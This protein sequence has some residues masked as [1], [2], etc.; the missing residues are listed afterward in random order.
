MLRLRT[1]P[2]LLLS[3]LVVP[4][5]G[6][7]AVSSC[8]AWNAS[9]C[10]AAFA[11]A[12]NAEI[13][14]SIRA[15]KAARERAFVAARNAEIEASLAAVEAARERDFAEARNAEII[16]SI[17]NV[18]IAR[19]IDA[20]LSRT[21]CESPGAGLEPCEGE[22]A[23]EF[24][25]ARNAEIEVSLAAANEQRQRAFTVAR[26]AEVDVSI[27]TVNAARERS[28]ALRP[29]SCESPNSGLPPCEGEVAARFERARNAEIAASLVAVSEQ[30]AFTEARNAEIEASIGAVEAVRGRAFARARNAEIKRSVAAAE[31]A[32]RRAFAQ[33]RNAEIELATAAV[34]AARE[35]DLA[36]SR[37]YCKSPETATPRCKVERAREFAAARN[38]EIAASLAAVEARREPAFA[39]ARNAEIRASIAAV[40]ITR[41]RTAALG[42]TR[43]T[44]RELPTSH[45]AAERTIQLALSRTHCKT[46]GSSSPRC[47]AE[48][49]HE[50]AIARNMEIGASIATVKAARERGFAAARNAEINAAFAAYGT[51]RTRSAQTETPAGPTAPSPLETGAI[52]IPDALPL[53][54]LPERHSL[55]AEPCSA[56]GQRLPPVQF[57]GV[58]TAIDDA[59]KPGLDRLADIARGCP[60]VRIEIHGYS[61][62]SG[63]AFVVRRL[64]ELRAQAALAYL[65]SAGIQRNRLAAIGHGDMLPLAP[66]TTPESRAKNRRVE[67]TIKDPALEAAAARI[68][69]D[70]AD[71]LDPTY[72][73]QLAR[74]S[75]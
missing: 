48:R 61:D 38:A 9:R 5:S 58:G 39:A 56:A 33:A 55:A 34:R 62:A 12:R 71:L 7:T 27:A 59:M 68:M 52:R 26:N 47:E 14:A 37:T 75:P 40:T 20:L 2:L 42:I 1:F 70:L 30:R 8:P 57:S 41:A 72:V 50:F 4:A 28:A 36:L 60:F 63:S 64:A 13:D 69:W 3:A 54:V 67:F 22:I 21:S 10:P 6:E 32:R 24:A 29:T 25:R 53:P 66:N 45:C 11:R 35:R 16:A 17:A 49:A 15:A 46:A 18:D 19:E 23:A 73:P 65:V 51:Q 74:L 31:A 43:C 44:G